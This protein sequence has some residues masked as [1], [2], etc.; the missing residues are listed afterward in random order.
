MKKTFYF[1]SIL[2]LFIHCSVVKTTSKGNTA[3]GLKDYYKNYFDIGV[4]V[5]ALVLKDKN[6]SL[7]LKEFSSLTAENSMKMGP[8]HPTEN[9]YNWKDADS[10]ITFANKHLLKIRGHNLCWHQQTPKWFFIDSLGKQVTKE[11]LLLRLKKHIFEV[12]GRYKGK[13][14]A[15]DVVNEAISDAPNEYLRN[16]IW[17]QIAGDEYISKAFEYA[18]EADPAALLFYNDYNEI[19]A[20]KRAKMIRLVKDLKLQGVPIN[21]VGLQAH[22]AINEPSYAQLDSTLSDF[23]QLGLILQI[24]ELDLSVYPKE[25]VAR[26]RQN[27]DTATTFSHEKEMKQAEVYKNCFELFRKYKQYISSVTFWNITDEHSWLD[28]FPVNNRKDYPLLFDTNNKRKHA[29]KEV[30]NWQK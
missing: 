14:Y 15:W 3:L 20:I 22:W 4:A 26:E 19:S 5:S 11:V 7:I 29:Y 9:V 1:L 8:I 12:V 27:I 25:H 16:S 30:V 2:I 28:N 24:T 6:A 17:Y 21:G 18:H 23:S 10:I 13:V